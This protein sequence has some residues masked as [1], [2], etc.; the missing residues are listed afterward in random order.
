MQRLLLP[1]VARALLA[2]RA[3]HEGALR[4]LAHEERQAK[5]GK[6]GG[7]KRAKAGEGHGAPAAARPSTTT[8]LG[9]FS[10]APSSQT[11]YETFVRVK[12]SARTHTVTPPCGSHCHQLRVR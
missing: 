4:A 8:I 5:E 2:A 3:R 6:R 1:A 12:P 10:K 11:Q 7:K 9:C